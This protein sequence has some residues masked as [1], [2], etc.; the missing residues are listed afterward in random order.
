MTEDEWF[1][2]GTTRLG[3][4]AKVVGTVYVP[5]FP[6]AQLTRP[7]EDAFEYAWELAGREMGIVT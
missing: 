4:W 2:L 5:G 3:E 6:E 1:H 7:E